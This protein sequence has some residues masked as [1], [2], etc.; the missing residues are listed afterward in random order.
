LVRGFYDIGTWIGMILVWFLLYGKDGGRPWRKAALAGLLLVALILMRRWTGYWVAGFWGSLSIL[1]VI[2]RARG[3]EPFW[4]LGPIT[5]AGG[6]GALLFLLL[7]PHLM[8]HALTQDTAGLHEPYKM[9]LSTWET[10]LDALSDHGWNSWV[11]AAIGG[12]WAWKEGKLGGPL[13]VILLQSLLALCFF[14]RVQNVDPHHQLQFLLPL[15]L[16]QAFFLSRLL[17]R[18]GGKPMAGILLAGVFLLNAGMNFVQP[19]ILRPPPCLKAGRLWV[20]ALGQP[21]RRGDLKEIARLMGT[22][23]RITAPDSK[24]YVLSSSQGFN[25]STLQNAAYYM[26][27][28]DPEVCARVFSSANVDVRDGFPWDLFLARYVLIAKPLQF[29]LLPRDQGVI[30]LPAAQIL[31]GRGIGRAFRALPEVFQLDGGVKV[32]VFER[33][34]K[35]RFPDVEALNRALR[36]AHPQSGRFSEAAFRAGR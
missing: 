14:S 29:H 15:V 24:V 36:E 33:T 32:W 22:L 9:G 34:G 7:A 16:L 26:A 8:V 28:A 25:S 19:L 4:G 12:W 5:V 27:F 20:E 17:G 2:A 11:F 21:D 18:G 30:G 35:I 10:L 23:Q 1:W 6:A 3:R 31:E 13:G